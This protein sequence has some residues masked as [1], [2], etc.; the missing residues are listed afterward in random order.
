MT[1]AKLAPL[2]LAVAGL[3][4]L[5]LLQK[6]MPASA[7]AGATL[8]VAY[9][10]AMTLCAASF[11]FFVAPGQTLL[12]GLATVPWNAVAMGVA[13]AACEIGILLTYRAGWPVGTTA[14]LTSALMT[15]VLFPVGVAAFGEALS[16]QRLGGLALTLAGLY[17]LTK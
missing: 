8:A 9:V 7:N 13:I 1:A 15:V 6:T 3:S 17:L 16:L 12:A 14:V 11:P 5:H 10:V 4:G 2:L